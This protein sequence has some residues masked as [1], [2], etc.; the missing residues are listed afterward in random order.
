MDNLGGTDSIENPEGVATTLGHGPVSMAE[1]LAAFSVFDN[2]GDRVTPRAVLRV[3][4]ASGKVLEALDP[5]AARTQVISSDLSYVM[6]DLM[7]GPVKAYLGPL[8]Q[9]PVACKS[10]TT[11][12]YTGSIFIGYTP[13]PAIA[14]SLMHLD[15]GP[16]GNSGSAQLATHLP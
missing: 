11:E 8:S 6:T 15:A 16:T 2:G 7:R 14:A 1:H 12:A 10:G 4:D 13:N 5:G 3:T 9:P